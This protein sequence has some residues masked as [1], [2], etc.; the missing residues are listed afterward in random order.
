M[1]YVGLSVLSFYLESLRLLRNQILSKV[2]KMDNQDKDFFD[3]ADSVS[4]IKPK[5][6]N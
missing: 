3:D 4:D 1:T 6:N 2:S 5:K